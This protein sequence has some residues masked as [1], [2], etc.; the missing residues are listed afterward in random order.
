MA[1][2]VYLYCG[3]ELT[4][5]VLAQITARLATEPCLEGLIDDTVSVRMVSIASPVQVC[6]SAGPQIFLAETTHMGFQP[7]YGLDVDI[8]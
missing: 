5:R 4:A 2:I 3:Q 1:D 7:A 8:T 6:R